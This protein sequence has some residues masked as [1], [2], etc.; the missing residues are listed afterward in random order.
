MRAVIM[1]GGQGARLRP[2]TCTIPKPM[3]KILSKP[4]MEYIIALLKQHGITEIAITLHYLPNEIKD[5][6]ADGTKFGVKLEYFI[7][8]SPLGTAGS[9]KACES[10][11]S[12]DFLVISGDCICDI[13]LSEAIKFHYNNQADATIVLN[14]VETPLEYGVVVT[15]TDGKINRFIE[16]PS[17][18][19]AYCDTVNTGIYIIKKQIMESVPKNK[20]YDFAKDLFSSLLGQNGRLY[21]YLTDKYWCD[22][23]DLEAYIRCQSDVL[24]DRVDI[25]HNFENQNG[26][27]LA[28]DT[29]KNGYVINKPVFLGDNV[30]IGQG[31]IIGP[32]AV[33]GDNCII[34]ENVSIKNSILYDKVLVSNDA[35]IRGSVLCSCSSVKEKASIFEGSVIGAHTIVGEQCKVLSSVKIWPYKVITD[36]ST[37][38]ENVIWG[39]NSMKLFQNN[40]IVG[41][42]GVDITPSTA[43]KIG[44]TLASLPANRIAVSFEGSE[45][46]VLLAKAVCLGCQACGADVVWL[47]NTIFSV[48]QYSIKEAGCTAAAHICGTKTKT[49]IVLM[50]SIGQL[51]NRATQRKLGEIFEKGEF[52]I[53]ELSQ[54]GKLYEFGIANSL[55]IDACEKLVEPLHSCKVCIELKS[56]AH[57][58]M[59]SILKSK[60]CK[61]VTKPAQGVPTIQISDGGRDYFITDEN[62]NQITKSEI[63]SILMLHLA[64][65]QYKSIALPPDAP[66]STEAICKLQ[67]CDVY[68]TF[69][70]PSAQED[71]KARLLLREQKYF[72]NAFFSIL[73]LLEICQQQNCTISSLKEKMPSLATVEKNVKIKK[74]KTVVFSSLSDKY[75]CSY[76]DGLKITTPSGSAVVRPSSDK[77]EFQIYAESAT[78]EAANEICAD[79]AKKIKDLD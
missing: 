37:V 52:S 43:L 14:K 55:F 20:P 27:I 45:S 12:D 68:R 28:S 79:I 5:Y 53:C 38:S 76:G 13:N 42:A 78:F 2:I 64:H 17:W 62:L 70:N 10:F 50:D 3:A 15:D 29:L 46:N 11:L 72:L 58:L 21:G 60:D 4:A 23:G 7:E 59:Y 33:I 49:Q 26:V 51:I 77:K 66:I 16:K 30:K 54:V 41:Q 6:F 34:G 75:K 69:L 47:S 73:L 8:S 61:V 57:K 71:Y 32:N 40:T 35:S 19:Q 25:P 67:G 31:S 39:S 56:P 48:A 65:S 1:A 63:Q 9:V 18:S 22:I 24:N 36:F 74:P 44:M